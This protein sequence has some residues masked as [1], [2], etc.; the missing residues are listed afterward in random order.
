MF[1]QNSDN[2]GYLMIAKFE[3]IYKELL[4]MIM[5]CILMEIS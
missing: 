5:F 4:K 2:F 1:F 3:I